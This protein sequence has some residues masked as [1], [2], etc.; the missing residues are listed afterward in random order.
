MFTGHYENHSVVISSLVLNNVISV[1]VLFTSFSL[2]VEKEKE[3]STVVNSIFVFSVT[4]KAM[5]RIDFETK[6]SLS[7][8]IDSSRHNDNILTAVVIYLLDFFVLF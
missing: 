6:C 1:E 7:S 5:F 8:E 2:R 3:G 4:Q